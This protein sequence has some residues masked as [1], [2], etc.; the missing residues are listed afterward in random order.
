MIFYLGTYTNLRQDVGMSTLFTLRAWVQIGLVGAVLGSASAH[1]APSNEDE[2][3]MG[4][5]AR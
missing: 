5:A 3:S 2:A 1:A 4:A